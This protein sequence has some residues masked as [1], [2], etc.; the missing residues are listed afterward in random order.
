MPT[1]PSFVLKLLDLAA[2][3]FDDIVIDLPNLETPW[4]ASVLSTSDEIFIV[5]ELNLASLRQAKRLYGKIR[6]LRGNGASITLVAN[7]QKRKWF[8]NHF[9][10]KELE[11]VFKA[12]NIRSVSLDDKLADRGAQSRHPAIRS[13]CARPLQQGAEGNVPR[14]A[15]S[16]WTL[17]PALRQRRC[18]LALP[19]LSLPGCRSRARSGARRRPPAAASDGA[20][21][22]Q[23][24]RLRN[25]RDGGDHR[26]PQAGKGALPDNLRRA[27]RF[28]TRSASDETVSAG[29]ERC[30]VGAKKEWPEW[31]PPTE[32][33][34][35]QAGL[36]EFVPAGPYN[37]LGARALYLHREG[38]DTLYRIHGTN[39]PKG[40][41]FDG[42][43]GCFRLTNTDVVDLFKRVPLGTKVVVE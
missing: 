3:R 4:Q 36:P 30:K 7:K 28:A 8:G 6:E 19:C 11:K 14:Q 27:R 17:G 5:F 12:P 29:P 21:P 18:G 43:S 39:D 38:R 42:T 37:P 26:H 33:R 13:R 10:R 1:A 23:Y 24:R 9:S 35:R 40:V 31:R 41:G 32:M 22:A 34:A 15:R 16:Q 2:Y 25:Q 20:E